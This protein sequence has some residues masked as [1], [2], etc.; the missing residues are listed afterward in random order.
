MS[1]VIVFVGGTMDTERIRVT[2]ACVPAITVPAID[3][4]PEERYVRA[5]DPYDIPV[6]FVLA[7]TTTEGSPA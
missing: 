1:A 7:T 2:T 5:S 6:R 3:G 4:L